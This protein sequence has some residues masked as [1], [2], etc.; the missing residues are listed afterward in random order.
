MHQQQTRFSSVC[1]SDWDLFSETGNQGIAGKFREESWG[2]IFWSCRRIWSWDAAV[3]PLLVKTQ[4]INAV[5]QAVARSAKHPFHLAVSA[6][7]LASCIQ[8]SCLGRQ[9]MVLSLLIVSHGTTSTHS[10]TP[11]YLGSQSKKGQT[12]HAKRKD[13][14]LI[15]CLFIHRATACDSPVQTY[16]HLKAASKLSSWSSTSKPTW[17]IFPITGPSQ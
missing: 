17:A 11:V 16:P 6:H 15:S 10:I 13:P 7:S 14:V 9:L 8:W 12:V 2:H 3:S 4:M 1:Q 5:L